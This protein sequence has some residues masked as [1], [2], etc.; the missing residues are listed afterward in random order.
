MGE[1]CGLLD[2]AKDSEQTMQSPRSTSYVLCGRGRR[3]SGN[4][5]ECFLGDRHMDV[6]V[7]GVT[8]NKGMC[9]NENSVFSNFIYTCFTTNYYALK[10][11]CFGDQE[12]DR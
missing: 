3:S 6:H 9:E 10:N 8:I 5:G 12:F 11:M 1:L 4:Q 7:I 2:K